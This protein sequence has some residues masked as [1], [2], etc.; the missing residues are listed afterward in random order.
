MP[1]DELVPGNAG[2]PVLR[3]VVYMRRGRGNFSPV[4]ADALPHFF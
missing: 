3:A 2:G 4:A 1:R